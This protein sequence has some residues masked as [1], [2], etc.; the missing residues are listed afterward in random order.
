MKAAT[1]IRERAGRIKL[2]IL[3]VDGVLTDG[4]IYLGPQGGEMKTFHV[5]DGSALVRCLRAGVVVALVSGRRSEAVAV[6]GRELG[7][8][9]VH[10]G[11]EDKIR[12]MEELCRR[13]SCR[14]EETACVGDDLPDLPLMG[15]AGLA[16]AV[17]DSHPAL[18][19][20]ADYV[21]GHRGGEGA[22]MEVVELILGAR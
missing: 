19:T 3:D 7:I 5:R 8:A 18:R 17:A 11:V 15:K 4:K 16:V 1:D 14:A 10:Q 9:E 2:L 20:A 13:Y 12:V 6:R 22:V 21:T